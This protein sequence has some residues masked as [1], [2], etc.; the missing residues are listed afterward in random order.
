M[1]YQGSAINLETNNPNEFEM[2]NCNS[3]IG[4]MNGFLR[5]ITPHR[6]LLRLTVILTGLFVLNAAAQ[7]EPRVRARDLG[8]APGIFSPGTHNAITDVA[9]VRVGQVTLIEGDNVRTGITAI[10]PHP[11]NTY[12]SRVPAALHVGNGFGKLSAPPKSTSWAN[13][14]ARSC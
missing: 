6:L 3:S 8:V 11:G 7:D 14:K 4:N 10:L 9:G 12:R 1:I 13:W 2:E 5:L